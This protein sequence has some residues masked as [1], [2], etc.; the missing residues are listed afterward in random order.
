MNTLRMST[1]LVAS[2]II[3]AAQTVPAFADN[4]DA[5]T[6]VATFVKTNLI[7]KELV[8]SQENPVERDA[9]SGKSYQV[10]WRRTAKYHNFKESANGVSFDCHVAVKFQTHVI[11]GDEQTLIPERNKSYDTTFHLEARQ[12]PGQPQ[13]RGYTTTL[14]ATT[15]GKPNDTLG[16][17]GLLTVWV[18]EDGRLHINQRALIPNEVE[19][20]LSGKMALQ[21]TDVFETLHVNGNK[22]VRKQ[23][24]YN[25]AVNP[26][27]L[28]RDHPW[29]QSDD[30]GFVEEI[31][32]T[33]PK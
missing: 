28:E 15:N 6:R 31:E 1:T 18:D 30:D 9:D 3:F 26:H 21:Y 29:E 2:V 25:Y 17:A 8:T 32:L 20:Q 7:D 14:A 33:E 27:T 12:F 11:D 5:K 4:N 16:M 19:K 10:S 13:L 22:L 23:F 24:F